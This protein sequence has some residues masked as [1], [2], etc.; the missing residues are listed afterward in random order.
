MVFGDPAHISSTLIA[1]PVVRKISFTGSTA[2]GKQ[3]AALAAAGIKRA[4]LELGGHAPVVVTA[5]AD[6]DRAV[7]LSVGFKYRNAGQVCVSPSRFL[8]QEGIYDEFASRFTRAAGD[9]RVA[10]GLEEGAQMGSLANERR[11]SSIHGLVE[12][13]IARGAK[14]Q[15]GGAPY[16][17][18]GF[19]YP[20]TVLTDIPPDARVLNEEPFGPIAAITTFRDIDQAITEAN[21]LPYGLA[22]YVF[23]QDVSEHIALTNGIEAGMIGVNH[24]G[25]SLAEI[26]FGGVKESGYGSEGGTEGIESYLVTKS[27]TTT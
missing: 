13:A 23:T 3:L 19:F 2:V 8:V 11:R 9:I 7:K 6:L 15:I 18:L 16:D 27:V 21:R 12:D 4:T 22:A 1:S 25:V 24:F 14:L 20:P 26:P 5:K 17:T 10:A